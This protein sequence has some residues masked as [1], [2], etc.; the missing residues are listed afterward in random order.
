[1]IVWD[2]TS[3]S[4]RNEKDT[5]GV[6]SETRFGRER[7]EDEGLIDHRKGTS[8]QTARGG[9]QRFPFTHMI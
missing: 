1:M 7:T 3:G 6:I 8:G 4:K 5:F 9:E 2:L